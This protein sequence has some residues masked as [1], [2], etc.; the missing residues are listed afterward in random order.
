MLRRMVWNPRW[1]ETLFMVSCAERLMDKPT[2]HSD[3]EIFD[4]ICAELS[5]A[6]EG[7]AAFLVFRLVYISRNG[8]VLEK[9]ITYISR[10]RPRS[11][12]RAGAA[13]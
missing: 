8:T 5:R 10:P 4:R 11:E 6:G 1:N 2:Q 13:Q 12:P 7:A 3:S 9:E